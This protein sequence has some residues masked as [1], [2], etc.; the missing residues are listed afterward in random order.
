MMSVIPT[1]QVGTTLGFLRLRKSHLPSSLSNSQTD[2]T[3]RCVAILNFLSCRRSKTELQVF[4]KVLR[5]NQNKEQ[6]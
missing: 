2:I 6:K 3:D 1:K 5:T 4:E